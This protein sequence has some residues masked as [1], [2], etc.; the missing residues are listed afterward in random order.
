MR[1]ILNIIARLVRV[2]WNTLKTVFRGLRGLALALMLVLNIA[3]IAVPSVYNV[4]SDVFWRTVAVVADGYAL[5]NETRSTRRAAQERAATDLEDSRIREA[6]LRSTR[7][8]MEAERLDLDRRLTQIDSDLVRTRDRL[9]DVTTQRDTMVVERQRMSRDL[10][11][12]SDELTTTRQRLNDLEIER[13]RLSDANV[14]LRIELD[15]ARQR[16]EMAENAARAFRVALRDRTQRVKS[17]SLFALGRNS[18]ATLTEMLPLIGTAAAVGAIALDI[19]DICETL[20]DMQAIE[21]MLQGDGQPDL[22]AQP[23]C[24]LST[25]D[26]S[27]A[28]FGGPV[29]A[30]RACI[31]ARLRTGQLDPPGCE[32]YPLT[33]GKDDEAP[34]AAQTPPLPDDNTF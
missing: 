33:R 29:A 24:R 17:R 12:V 23:W 34:P 10:N 9:D 8:R 7:D 16:Q 11:R 26:I 3:M 20:D 32:D 30:E 1:L 27:N 13:I 5:Q 18:G 14:G 22:Q 21:A 25:A 28:L 15:S 2:L 6:D 31:D 19:K 4:V